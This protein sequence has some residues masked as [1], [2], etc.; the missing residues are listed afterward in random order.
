MIVTKL[1]FPW[2]ALAPTC[3]TG[4]TGDQF[5][6]GP[7]FANSEILARCLPLGELFAYSVERIFFLLYGVP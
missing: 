7:S 1:S 2:I 6:I 4:T 5:G 3:F